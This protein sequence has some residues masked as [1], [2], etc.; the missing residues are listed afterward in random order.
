MKRFLKKLWSKITSLFDKVED[1]TKKLVPIA[2][3]VVEGI[4]KVM[5][6]PVDDVVLSVVKSAIPGDADDILIDKVKSVVE[7]WLPKILLEMRLIDSIANVEDPNDQMLKILE[8]FKL[9]SDETKNIFYHGFCSLILE[10]LS[11][12]E[13][14]WSDAIVISE[15]YFKNHGASEGGNTP[16]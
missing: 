15:Y 9:S 11:D 4:K 7:K 14:S 5:D 2:I 16:T 6:S 1:K 8:Q 10:K 12:G 3:N 13:I